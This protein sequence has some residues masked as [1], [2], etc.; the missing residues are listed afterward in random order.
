MMGWYGGGMGGAWVFIGLFWIALIAVIIWLVIRLL[1][2]S[3]R[4]DATR[5]TTPASMPPMLSAPAG[6]SALDILDRRFASGE[7]DLATYQLHRAALIAARG[8]S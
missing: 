5:S 7:I 1:P 8:G 6:E 2:S 4:A 3:G